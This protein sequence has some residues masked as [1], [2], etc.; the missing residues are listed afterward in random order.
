MENRENYLREELYQLIKSDD[1]IFDFI[2]D[3][4]IDGLWYW[5][6]DNLEQ[7]WMNDRFWQ[8]LGY[9]PQ[10]KAHLSAEWQKI[11]NQDDLKIAMS[12]FHRHCSDP[13]HPYDQTVRY[14]H[15]NGSTVWI[16][17]RG[18]AIRD[19]A[20]LAHRML[21]AHCD[22]TKLKEM[23][24]QYRRNLKEIDKTYAITKL[25]FEESEK[26]FEMAPD[27]N[28][29][30]DRSGNIVKANKQASAIF[31]YGKE[32]LESMN[33]SDLMLN[34]H[35]HGH[36]KNLEKY[37]T[38]GGARKMGAER[39]QLLA[40]N[41][42]GETLNVEITLNLID[43]SYG[44]CALATIRDV[45]E[46]ENLIR[47]LQQQLEENKKLEELTLIDPLTNIFNNRHYED[48]MVKEL[49]DCSRYQHDLSLIM[50]DIDHFKV[51]NDEKGHI[52]GNEI[53]I[54]LV[55][56]I[57][58]LIRLNDTFA[59]IGGEEFA[60]ILPQSDLD[61]S[62]AIAERIVF[63]VENHTFILKTSEKIK[64][65]V[66]IGVT[67]FIDSSDT[68]SSLYERADNALYQSKNQGRNRVTAFET[69][70]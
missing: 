30:V 13:T 55:Q 9:D 63:E 6:L 41:S 34:K 24:S 4:C 16:R 28:L 18:I 60:I 29:K 3:A 53:L 62:V 43:T 65:T 47:S 10:E 49:S 54:Q 44:K 42:K 69:K 7:E 35:K 59:R 45:S 17:C 57:S 70:S 2:F 58:T 36:P 48:T 33:I 12:N 38:E 8:V 31:G 21:G 39:G 19:E 56:L 68:Y 64:L 40:I 11:I 37:F 61:T 26:L 27:A 46:K 67:S 66:S 20:G 14:Q 5:D 50:L 23:E 32:Q 1:S 22:I 51:I 52:A 25:A 15:K